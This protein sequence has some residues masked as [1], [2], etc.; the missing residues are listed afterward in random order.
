[1]R[2]KNKIV[3]VT[4]ASS[5][6]GEQT[7]LDFAKRGADIVLLARS[8]SRMEAISKKI[9]ENYQTHTLVIQC[10]V[11]K[12]VQVL[13]MSKKVFDEFDHVDIL[14]NNAGFAIFGSVKDLSIEEMEEQIKT[15]LFGAI[16]CTKAFLPSMLTRKRGHIVNI[17]SVAGSIGVPGFASYCASKFGMVGFSQSLYHELKGTGIGVT[18]VSPI[19]VKT[20]FFNHPSFQKIKLNYIPPGLSATHVSN[21]VLRAANSKR[22]EM[23]VPFYV[24]GAVWLIQTLPYLLNPI[25]GIAFRKHMK[26]LEKTDNQV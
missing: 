8:T 7:C 6:I 11:S 21:A 25:I 24:R 1:M 15:N 9:R 3:V 12:K 4:G 17:A 10:D 16:Y 2:F 14:V 23:I 22:L 19:T 13:S 5:G 18:V 20:N 26:N